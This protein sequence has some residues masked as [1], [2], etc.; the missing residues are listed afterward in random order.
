VCGNLDAIPDEQKDE[1]FENIK[2]LD[3]YFDR[4][5]RSHLLKRYLIPRMLST[6]NMEVIRFP[7]TL[8]HI[9]TTQL[10]IPEG[11]NFQSEPFN[12]NG[13]Q[14]KAWTEAIYGSTDPGLAKESGRANSLFWL[15]DRK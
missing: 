3:V 4:N 6:L 5:R 10:Y 14:R 9:R 8:V 7:E 12:E 13:H 11:G 15:I 1:N 2:W